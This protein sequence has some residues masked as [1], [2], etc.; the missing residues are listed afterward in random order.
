MK[1]L[2]FSPY[3]GIWSHAYPEALVLET[4]KQA[5][6]QIRYVTCDEVFQSH[7]HVMSAEGLSHSAAQERK[8]RACRTC[9]ARDHLL[10]TTFRFDG[11]RL[12]ERIFPEDHAE[13]ERILSGLSPENLLDL[14]TRGH[15]V[16]RIGIYS[17]LIELKKSSL[18]FSAA[19]WALV[20]SE[21]RHTL[22][23]LWASGRI[24]DEE[25]PDGVVA[26]NG[27]YPANRILFALAEERGIPAYALHAGPNLS[28]RVSSMTISRRDSWVSLFRQQLEHWQVLKDEPVTGRDMAR[29]TDHFL[30][31]FKGRNVFAYSS[32][33][34]VGGA[35]IRQRFGI[36]EDQKLLVAAMS[37]YDERFAAETAGVES[38]DY[39]SL[40]FPRQV[41]WIRALIDHCSHHP[42]LFLL[43]RVHPREFPNKREG[44]KSSHAQMLEK[45]L[46]E[47]PPN[48]RVNWPTDGVSMYDLAEETDVV[49]T[50]WSS[51]GKEMAL[52]GI[53]VVAFSPEL[54][55]YP[56][57]LNY[58][59]TTRETY[60]SQVHRA[61]SEGWSL[62][63]SRKAYRWYALEFGPTTIDLSESVRDP[64]FD[65]R[66]FL[67]RI[68]RRLRREIDPL[69]RDKRELMR[70]APRLRDATIIEATFE[71]RF[72][73]ALDAALAAPR[74]K[75]TLASE[76]AA[77]RS[78]L[79]R[80]CGGLY[81]A[82]PE[83][84][85]VGSLRNHLA[86][87]IREDLPRV[88]A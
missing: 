60:F 24:L 17:A 47:L 63:N 79:A 11:F 84:G 7:C 88:L 62:E 48:A 37:S 41:D 30:E 16:G 77:L 71:N 81:G 43:I 18:D 46:V 25:R 5:G 70:R 33:R 72:R 66:T 54:I 45:V 44:R 34:S 64:V 1:I 80:L 68:Y 86:K 58:V 26:Y 42:E 53:P 15:P 29:V 6:H 21:L 49:L 12:G 36:R 57:D 50:A 35:D 52:L 2:A 31:L 75:V 74:H 76:T 67:A 20:K 27:L 19:E 10:R 14:E 82:V 59:G 13:A 3:S 56:P 73:T 51:V 23:T 4:L 78:E 28:N 8:A 39:D 32:P 40:V 22:L 55:V 61:I 38:I 69:W 87:A 85:R 65:S 9:H 83:G